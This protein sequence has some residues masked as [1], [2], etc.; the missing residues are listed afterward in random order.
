[1]CATKSVVS[2]G[3]PGLVVMGDVSR[4]KGCGFESRRRILDGHDIFSHWFVVK[5]VCL[6]EKTENKRKRGRGWP[7]FKKKC[8]VT[9]KKIGWTEWG[10]VI[11]QWIRLR[12]PYCLP[13]VRV[14]STPSTLLS[15]KLKFVLYFSLECEKNKN[16]NKEEDWLGPFEKYFDGLNFDETFVG[17]AKKVTKLISHFS[18]VHLLCCCCCYCCCYC[19]CCCCCCYCCCCYCCYFC[20]CYCCCRCCVTEIDINQFTFET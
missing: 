9:S 5:I 20:C 4:S 7:I 19:C 13:Q 6:F 14:L 1:M 2:G 10:V 17:F 11:V 16:K 3:C 8:C 15:F 18:L 12:L